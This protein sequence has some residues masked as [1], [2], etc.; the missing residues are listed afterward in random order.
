MWWRTTPVATKTRYHGAGGA[1]FARADLSAY[2]Y[3]FISLLW[4]FDPHVFKR[5][6]AYFPL[7][8]RLAGGFVPFRDPIREALSFVNLYFLWVFWVLGC[9]P[10]VGPF[11]SRPI[12]GSIRG[13]GTPPQTLA[14]IWRKKGSPFISSGCSRKD[15]EGNQPPPPPPH[16]HVPPP[17]PPPSP[18]LPTGYLRAAFQ[19]PPPLPPPQAAVAAAAAGSPHLH[20]PSPSTD[21]HLPPQLH[22]H[23]HLR[24]TS[25][26]PFPFIPLPQAPSPPSPASTSPPHSTISSQILSL[27]SRARPPHRTPI[28]LPPPLPC[29]PRH[30]PSFFPVPIN[31]AFPA[32]RTPSLSLHLCDLLPSPHFVT[33]TPR[34]HPPCFPNFRNEKP[35][36]FPRKVILLTIQLP[37][38]P[39][40]QLFPISLFD[41]PPSY[42][43]AFR[44]SPSAHHF[45]SLSPIPSPTQS[46]CRPLN[47]QPSRHV[48]QPKIT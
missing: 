15:K 43:D 14:I 26:P 11:P 34:E 2:L 10:Q 3:F 48:V 40:F 32:P 5:V 17:C 7:P 33:S 42:A 45:Y 16:H 8:F 35:S 19:P 1:L 20:L 21:H 47:P 13:E 44:F 22:L 46:A 29:R 37:H 23:L 6:L 36:E 38:F 18:A 31:P 25:Q 12:M 39:Q 9:G 28:P 24:R 30:P 41:D 4:T 27:H